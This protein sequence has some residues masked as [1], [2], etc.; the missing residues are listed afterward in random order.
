MKESHWYTFPSSDSSNYTFVWI[1]FGDVSALNFF[2]MKNG[3]RQFWSKITND[4]KQ[5]VN[6]VTGL[7]RNQSA[8]YL[9]WMNVIYVLWQHESASPECIFNIFIQL[10]SYRLFNPILVRC[11]TVKDAYAWIIHQSCL[12][13]GNTER[14][15][16]TKT[17]KMIRP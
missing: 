11:V 9:L 12:S 2:K 14:V 1:G 8:E 17:S 6:N 5:K 10:K 4:S 13:K 16:V 7:K 15:P 3:V